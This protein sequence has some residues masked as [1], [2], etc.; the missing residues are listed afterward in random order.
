MRT[1]AHRYCDPLDQIWLSTARRIDL[2][3]ERSDE[4]YASTDGAGVLTIGGVPTLDPD[5]SLAQMIFH[6]L[7]HSL[8]EGPDAFD[9]PDW[10]LDNTSQRDT[11]REHACLR[12][13]AGLSAEYGLRGFFAPTTD[14]RSFYD[15]LGPDPFGP[16]RAPSVAWA[17]AAIR[18]ADK[19]P[20][21]P[22]LRAA[23]DATAQ[24]ARAALHFAVP[25]SAEDA[26]TTPSKAAPL[27]TLWQLVEPAP[28]RHQTG[29]AMAPETEP[30]DQASR[31][32][33]ECAWHYRGGPGRPVDRC[34]QADG[35]RIS[36]EW[37][38]CN[39]W[40]GRLD[41]QECGACC[42]E[43][44]HSVT[45]SR[46]EAVTKSHPDLIVDR[47]P[48]IE[49]ARIDDPRGNRC[50]ALQ[51]G[52]YGDE[53][54]S[55]SGLIQISAQSNEWRPYSCTIYGDRPKPCRELENGGPHCL[56]ARRRVGLSR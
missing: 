7:C 49:L 54:P 28:M 23:L 44:Y 40:E 21:A 24:I 6:E 29:F 15:A 3:I 36:A 55:S 32:C 34:R 56:T 52:K 1:V 14:F 10:G 4:V 42:R 46:R 17:I 13:Q 33:G 26:R 30:D 2:R 16:R 27:P 53:E 18:R 43:A 51:G 25:V 11:E 8:V 20:W 35:A 50:A 48:Y 19:P 31:T 39:R 5:D 12:L 47:G 37:T 9:R 38:A 41:C 45:I 22:H